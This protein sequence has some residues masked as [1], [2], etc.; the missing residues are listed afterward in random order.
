[1]DRR[2]VGRVANQSWQDYETQRG[3]RD[4][5]PIPAGPMNEGIYKVVWLEQ[6]TFEILHHTQRQRVVLVESHDRICEFEDLKLLQFE[7]LR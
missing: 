6:M 3:P 5:P 2:H 1:M 7:G 4:L